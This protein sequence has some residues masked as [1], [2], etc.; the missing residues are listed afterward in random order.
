MQRAE[1]GERMSMSVVSALSWDLM[2]AM[3][4]FSNARCCFLSL[5]L[6]LEGHFLPCAE[7]CDGKK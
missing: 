6:R 4:S 5:D 2:A 3:R 1:N 7:E